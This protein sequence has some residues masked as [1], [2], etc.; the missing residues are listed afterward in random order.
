MQ[1]S[2]KMNY[3][4][5]HTFF[6]ERLKDKGFRLTEQRKKLINSI[7]RFKSP[8]SASEVFDDLAETGIDLTTIYRSLSSFSEIGILESLDFLDGNLRYEYISSE[9]THHH[10]IVCTECR[11]V[12]KVDVCIS[13]KQQKLVDQLGYKNVFHKLEF[14]GICSSCSS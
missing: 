14:F 10:H 9:N 8:F 5:E 1:G 4:K 2:E 12:K 7:L 11:S 6:V 3:K 13:A